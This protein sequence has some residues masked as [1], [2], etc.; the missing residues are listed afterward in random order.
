MWH[1]LLMSFFVFIVQTDLT[2]SQTQVEVQI[3]GIAQDAGYPQIGCEDSCCY[4]AW[5]NLQLRKSPV[6][7]GIYDLQSQKS[8]IV[9]ATPDLK[10]Q[11]QTHVVRTG[12]IPDGFLITHAHTGHYTGLMQLG[13]EMMNSHQMPVYV[14]PRLASFLKQNGPWDQLTTLGN[15]N[16][17]EIIPDSMFRLSAN[18]TCLAM[19]VPHRDEY[20]ETAGFV[21]TGPNKKLLFIPDID[22]WAKW[23]RNISSIVREVDYA[24][25][26]GTFFRNG[27]LKNRDMSQIPHPFVSESVELFSSLPVADRQKIY[28]IHFNH[29]N[30]LIRRDREAIEFVKAHQMNVAEEG[31]VIK[32]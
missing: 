6:C 18:V 27:E 26:D 19:Q 21:F 29:T 20:S 23:E 17:V 32:L 8:W 15:I 1:P 7:L 16:L 28:F 5:M 4:D 2:W 10:T 13:R 14:L 25:L 31:M 3:L 11:W 22:K 12:K 30:P 24:F 9:E